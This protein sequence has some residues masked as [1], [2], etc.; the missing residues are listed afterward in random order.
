MCYNLGLKDLKRVQIKQKKSRFTS[1]FS[2]MNLEIMLFQQQF[3]KLILQL[4]LCVN[5]RLQR[6][7]QYV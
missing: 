7:Y 2:S 4:H 3:R 6:I 5:E 1:G